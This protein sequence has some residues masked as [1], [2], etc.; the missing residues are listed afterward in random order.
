MASHENLLL[1][2][3]KPEQFTMDGIQVLTNAKLFS[4]ERGESFIDTEH[5]LLGII[6]GE[7]VEPASSILLRAANSGTTLDSINE[8][9]VEITGPP[10]MNLGV[11]P[12]PVL[13]QEPEK[14]FCLHQLKHT[15]KSKL[16]SHLFIC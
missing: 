13:L 1:G 12:K 2:L 6:R 3:Y 15:E 4:Q 9:I 16:E 14:L 8:L 11:F 10:P 7:G 5:L